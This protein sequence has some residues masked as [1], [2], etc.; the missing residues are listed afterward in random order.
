MKNYSERN[1]V[2]QEIVDKYRLN[3]SKL[4][5]YPIV[6][7]LNARSEEVELRPALVGNNLIGDE[8]SGF[9]DH[10]YENNSTHD[11]NHEMDI[12]V[13]TSNNDHDSEKKTAQDFLFCNATYK[14]NRKEIHFP[15][16]SDFKNKCYHL[17][18]NENKKNSKACLYFITSKTKK[19]TLLLFLISFFG[20]FEISKRIDTLSL[21][22]HINS[23]AVHS[24]LN[25]QKREMV[26]NETT[27]KCPNDS[28]ANAYQFDGSEQ[29]QSFSKF[30]SNN[31]S[32]KKNLEA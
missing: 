12:G 13:P 29:I 5:K 16:E 8:K 30:S 10:G 15:C 25:D 23:S 17:N 32:N 9:I 1:Q 31:Y 20:I 24:L 3:E 28:C 14:A 26:L 7:I 18:A 22:T 19:I 6:D 27:L 4:V 21:N 11:S 2:P